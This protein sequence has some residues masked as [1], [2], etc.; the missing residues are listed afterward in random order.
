M[1]R[2]LLEIITPRGVIVKEEVE[3]LVAP[4]YYGE[5]GVL[6]GHAHLIAALKMGVLSYKSEGRRRYLAIGDGYAEVS[7]DAAL[8]LIEEAVTPEEIEIER[9]REE[10]KELET[11]LSELKGDE[12][13]YQPLLR[14][15]ERLS[16]RE[17]VVRRLN[18]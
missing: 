17:E 5:F 7:P 18:P 9:V 1:E 15:I 14:S 8:L 3:E 4:G 11:R 12:E 6:P 16:I 13:E 2:F 10:K